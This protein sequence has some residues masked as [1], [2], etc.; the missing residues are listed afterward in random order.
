MNQEHIQQLL[1]PDYTLQWVIGN[2]GMS[3]VWLADDNRAGREVAIK[4]L[5]PEF[6]DNQEFLS[7]FRNEALAS[8]KIISDN[9]V[10][11][12]DYLESTDDRGRTM[13]FIV[14][15]YVRGESLA[16]MLE[17]KQTL[18]EELAL[19]LLEQ[20]AHGL[21]I[22]HRMG[23][24]HRDIKPGNLLVTQNGQV[25]ITDFGIAKAAAATPLTRTGMVVGTAQYVSPEQ[26]QG[27]DVT[28]ASDIYSLGVVG[29]EILAG[30]RPFTGDSSVSVAIAHINQAPPPL[31]TS[32]SAPARELIGITLR[33]DPSHRYANG[34]EFALAIS[35]T[36]LGKRPPQPT[37]VPV[38]AIAP[39]PSPTASTHA[40]GQ[41]AQPPEKQ[42]RSFGVGIGVAILIAL[43]LGAGM[44]VYV[45]LSE[46][47]KVT[48]PSVSITPPTPETVTV[49][50][51]RPTPTTT[52]QPET[53]TI[54]PETTSEQE[55][56][57]TSFSPA[58]PE[59][60]VE[61]HPS[62]AATVELTEDPLATAIDN[63]ISQINSPGAQQ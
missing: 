20:A 29:Y 17:R 34:N 57:T 30:H 51:Q 14:M 54:F 52:V 28:A 6:S 53:P 25:K 43:L 58:P 21:S 42:S 15:E 18:P 22:I 27:H 12:Y 1:G 33:K 4:V 49:T 60:S 5:R 23:M 7:R 47:S 11:T 16:D 8:E 59:T 26:A 41:V 2:G 40:L 13:C 36:R 62:T 3:T 48:T 38:T 32:I 24:V 50:A 37:A 45:K 46:E 10:R 44:W 35:A 39:Q 56:P 63:L 19:D 31:P 9:V 55:T 61:D